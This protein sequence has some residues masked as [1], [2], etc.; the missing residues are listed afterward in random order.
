[1]FQCLPII[2]TLYESNAYI[3][4]YYFSRNL[5]IT[6]QKMY[7]VVVISIIISLAYFIFR[8][9]EMKYIS[10]ENIPLKDIIKDSLVVLLCSILGTFIFVSLETTFYEMFNIITDNKNI[11]PKMTE[12]FID[13]PGF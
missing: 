12:V 3:Y 1:M 9:I 7:R 2:L 11:M 6:I 8:I 4:L 10:K 5:Y 13:E